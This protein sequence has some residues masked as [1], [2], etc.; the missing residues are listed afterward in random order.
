M[1]MT[2]PDTDFADLDDLFAQARAGDR[3]DN[4]FVARVLA[5][6]Y[7]LQPQTQPPQQASVPSPGLWARLLDGL[8]GW[9]ALGGLSAAAAAGV[10]LG[11]TPPVALADWAGQTLGLS[12]TVTLSADGDIFGLTEG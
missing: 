9:P 6:A 11:V 3:P 2:R 10:W 12:E 8:G 7:G 4:A 1:M 5:D